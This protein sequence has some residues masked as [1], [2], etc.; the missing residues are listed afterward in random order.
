MRRRDCAKD[1]LRDPAVAANGWRAERRDATL[2]GMLRAMAALCGY[3]VL[4][5]P[6]GAQVM[7]GGENA[8]GAVTPEAFAARMEASAR[9]VTERYPGQSAARTAEVDMALPT[10]DDE[11]GGYA[12]VLIAAQS[13]VA[14]E[15]PLRRAYIRS[16]DGREIELQHAGSERKQVAADSLAASVFGPFGVYSFYW[17]P[18]SALLAPGELLVDF[19][20]GRT[21]FRITTLPAV[22][23]DAGAEAPLAGAPDVAALTALRER[24]FPGF[25]PVQAEDR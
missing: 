25:A 10:A 21:G 14:A 8:Y 15:L 22:S 24:E 5:T 6:A 3:V 11:T 13:H 16:A 12:V 4:A 17:A 18:T 7:L 23:P 19:A 2:D 9:E 20:T 1:A